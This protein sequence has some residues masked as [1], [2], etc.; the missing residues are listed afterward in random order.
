M[1]RA[2]WNGQAEVLMVH[3][4]DRTTAA[5]LS[6]TLEVPAGRPVE[7]KVLVSHHP[8]GDWDLVVRADGQFLQRRTVGKATARGGWLEVRQ[9][10][11]A[12]GGRK[13]KLELL[14][15]PSGWS[16]E[17]GYFGAIELNSGSPLPAP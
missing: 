14:N 6:R 11:S 12:F 2:E 9:D 5:V 15:Q 8:Q 17:A 3:P 13:V 10:L 4:L 7:L 16:Y 1:V